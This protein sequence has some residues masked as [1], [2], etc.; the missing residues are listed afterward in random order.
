MNN[1]ILAIIL[2]FLPISELRGG[3][4][5]AVKYALDNNLSLSLIFFVI[6]LVNILAIFFAFFFMDYLHN[7][8]MKLSA[9]RRFFTKYM[10]RIEKSGKKVEKRMGFIGYFALMLFVSIPFPTTGAWTGSVIAWFL[11]LDRKKSL[12]AISSGVVLAG[13]I[14]LSI[15]LGVFNNF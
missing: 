12:I 1:L 11:K 13:L 9:Y 6:V 14:V 15:S 5:I 8:F 7:H 3:L 10:K 2:S 4:P